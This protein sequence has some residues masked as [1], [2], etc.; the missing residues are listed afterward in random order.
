MS[1]ATTP[2][3]NKP[4][5]PCILHQGYGS[6]CV[7]QHRQS[8]LPWPEAWGLFH[9]HWLH[10]ANASSWW[11]GPES[12]YHCKKYIR[13]WHFICWA[14]Q[15]RQK[16]RSFS[17]KVISIYGE[18]SMWLVQFTLLNAKQWSQLR[19]LVTILTHAANVLI[20][21]THDPLK[22]CC[23]ERKSQRIGWSTLHLHGGILK[24][25][26]YIWR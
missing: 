19:K 16:N 12:S 10:Q 4:V 11:R 9:C 26:T 24:L 3:L 21:S 23:S 17:A 14:L 18:L 5:H 7:V 8:T 13:P 1:S 20:F 15:G 2:R 6:Q 25:V 22:L